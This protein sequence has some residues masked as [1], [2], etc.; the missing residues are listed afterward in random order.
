MGVGRAPSTGGRAFS[1]GCSSPRTACTGAAHGLRQGS[2]EA[3]PP[4]PGPWVLSGP[5]GD[6]PSQGKAAG[7][8]PLPRTGSRHQPE[9]LCVMLQQALPWAL[10]PSPLLPEGSLGI[11][12]LPAAQEPEA[13]APKEAAPSPRRRVCADRTRGR[14]AVWPHRPCPAHPEMSTPHIRF[15]AGLQTLRERC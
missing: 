2:R 9:S 7:H 11:L 15:R 5:T 1:P 6:F 14:R 8:R 3:P 10:G 13:A 12:Q 4:P